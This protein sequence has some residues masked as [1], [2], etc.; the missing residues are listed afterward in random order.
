MWGRKEGGDL[1]GTGAEIEVS[2]LR[3][4]ICQA[5]CPAFD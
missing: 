3:V 5:V 2:N 4:A 1:R